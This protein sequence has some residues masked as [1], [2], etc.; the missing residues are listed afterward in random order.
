MTRLAAQ[1][2]ISLVSAIFLLLLFAALA[3]YMVRFVEAANIASVQDIQGGQAYH[4]AQAGLEWGAYQV[5]VPAAAS[6]V[7]TTTLPAAIGDFTV[8]VT[9]NAYGPYSEAGQTFTVYHLTA[10]AG[11]SAAPGSPGFV[12]RQVTGVLAR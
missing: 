11:N 12:E 8:R 3:A 7:G 2:G 4:A 6:C 1:R 10:T 9:C 5:A